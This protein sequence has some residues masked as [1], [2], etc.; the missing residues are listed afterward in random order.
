M[1]DPAAPDF[2]NTPVGT[3]RP[4]FAYAPADPCAPPQV[5][6]ITPFLDAGPVFLD[7]ARSVLRQ[8]FQQWEWLIVNDGSTDAGSLAILD[9]YRGADPR[10]R[11]IDHP[12]N[13]GLSAARNSAAGA[14]RTPYIVQLD[15]DDLLEPTA[16][17]KWWW[18][19]ESNPQLAFVKGYSVG[20]GAQHYL[21]S[22]GFHEGRAF[23][24]D[25][26]VDATSMIR[27]E[28]FQAVGGSDESIRGGLED[29]DFW[30]R[31]AAAGHW[32]DSIPEYLNWY[33]RRPSQTDRWPNLRP[34][35][36]H[37]AFKRRLRRRYPGLW[38]GTFPQPAGQDGMSRG[39]IPDVL[40]CENRLRKVGRRLLVIVPWLTI[41]GA[42][43]FVLDLLSQLS[44]RGW[45]TSVVTTL[46]GDHS[47]QPRATAHTPDVFVLHHFLQLRDYPRF[48]RYLIASRQHDLVLI[49]GSE[50]GYKLLPYLRAHFPGVAF[51]DFTHNEE[52][53]WKEGGYPRMAVSFQDLLDLSLVSSRYLKEWMTTRG[54]EPGRVEVCHTNVDG[55]LWR[56]D[57]AR[58]R[59]TRRELGIDADTPMLLFAGRMCAQK[60]PLM[61]ADT[62][63]AL[64][65]RG[66]RFVAV[67]A[68]DGPE[69]PGLHAFVQRH[70]LEHRLRLPGAVPNDRVRDLMTA[71]DV[72]F[73]PSEHEGIALSIYEAMATGLCVVG[74]DV[75]GQR[76]L[77]T[78]ECGVLV[79]RS[80]DAEEAARYDAVLS[81]LLSTPARRQAM[82]DA[83]RVRVQERFRLEQ[84]GD[85]MAT[86]LGAAL[87][88]HETRPRPR[89][90][91]GLGRACAAEV[92]EHVRLA[93]V[94][95]RLWHQHAGQA[96]NGSRHRDAA[97]DP[98][99]SRARDL[100]YFGIRA[101]LLPHYRRAATRKGLRW[102]VPLK[103]GIKYVLRG[104]GV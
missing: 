41:G 46:A 73:L 45:E 57:V 59:T 35:Q 53:S 71:A 37:G 5:T 34:E 43:K 72:F 33:R 89:I 20:F 60:R 77:V 28:V 16:V 62:V 7:T 96:G 6:I 49:H 100:F 86:L 31:C 101:M 82:G 1:I 25:N 80:T 10:I 54:A 4:H 99:H 22:R 29:W 38:S 56:P 93:R 61:L 9:E 102:L 84:M 94:A 74:A 21:W 11:V 104:T 40:P 42:D 15:S 98:Y 88:L 90:P 70:G 69:L 55:D 23:L 36:R 27:Y 50:L 65:R 67:A 91:L 26:L 12:V 79:A 81:E 66:V 8:S 18:C 95:E 83:G 103:N 24:E 17:E 68:G 63:L 85:R 51:V 44:R 39:T 75:G 97:W 78:P 13:R 30:L 3:R 64:E 76:E 14:A 19:L 47:G 87:E 48:L 92:V 2:D 52:R 58:R 32:G